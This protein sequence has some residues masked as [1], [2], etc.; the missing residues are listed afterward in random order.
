MP[1]TIGVVGDTHVLRHGGYRLAGEVGELFARFGV[2]LILH[3]GDANTAAVLRELG[4]VAPVLAVVGNNDDAELRAVLPETEEFAVG[5]FRF[6]MLHGDGGRSARAEAARR[7]AGRVDCVVYGH[8]HIPKM[9][10]QDGSILFNPGSATDRR[11]QAH[12]GVGLI[13]VTAE[14]I[15]PELVLFDDPRHLVNVRRETGDASR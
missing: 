2:G 6:A 5:P 11:W 13:R 10:V 7:F 1:L 15:E 8:S 12:F 14:G 3:V 9:E 4:R